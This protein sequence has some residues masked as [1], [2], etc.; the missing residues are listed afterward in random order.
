M[1]ITISLCLAFI[2]FS[3]LSLAAGT[4]TTPGITLPPGY[5]M[6]RGFSDLDSEQPS[7]NMFRT[8]INQYTPLEIRDSIADDQRNLI[9]WNDL[10]V[11]YY[12]TNCLSWVTVTF[13]TLG[14]PLNRITN[15]YSTANFLTS[16]LTEQWNTSMNRWENLYRTNTDRIVDAPCYYSFNDFYEWNGSTQQWQMSG[17]NITINSWFTGS[18]LDSIER[19][20]WNP[21]TGQYENAYKRIFHY[22]PSGSIQSLEIAL[23]D[24]GS[25]LYINNYRYL[26]FSFIQFQTACDY[27]AS[28]WQYQEWDGSSWQTAENFINT[29][30]GND[31]SVI[32]GFNAGGMMNYYESFH[33]DAM[34][35]L[36]AHTQKNFYGSL[37]QIFN[38]D[39]LYG[40]NNELLQYTQSLNDTAGG[41]V[42][43][44][45]KRSYNLNVL[46]SPTNSI[47]EDMNLDDITL[48]PTPADNNLTLSSESSHPIEYVFTDILGK[49]LFS[50]KFIKTTSIPVSDLHPGYYF[51]RLGGISG[52]SYKKVVVSHR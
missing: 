3:F 2:G 46:C 49:E 17:S 16:S 42:Y 26:Y 50:G 33:Y 48:Y 7:G 11:N 37:P 32:Q 52:A 45:F 12:P 6:G 24:P 13:D 14:Y 47:I 28:N 10:T 36:I 20:S 39:Y 44:T 40:A 21:T 4:K 41:P 22:S 25:G 1:K 19:Q 35:N 18:R 5:E 38:E 51:I 27:W 43:M 8:A 31:S 9:F 23:W 29:V 30:Y 15:T 34:N